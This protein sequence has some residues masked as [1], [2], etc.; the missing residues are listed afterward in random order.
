MVTEANLEFYKSEKGYQSITRWYDNLLEKFDFEYESQYV[1]TRF[2]P[3]HMLVSGPEDAEPL[4]LVQA[5][6]GSAPLWYHQMPFLAKDFRVYA[7]DTP[8]QPGRSAPN[9][10]AILEGGYSDWLID[11][12][13]GL[14]IERADFIGVSFAGWVVMRLAIRNP[15]RV[16]RIMMISPTG[17]VNARFP[18]GIFLR[19]VVSKKK[20]DQALEDDLT[21]RS[22]MPTGD[23]DGREFD[24][25]L[26]RAM[27]LATRHYKL[28]N[29]LGIL[30]EEKGRPDMAMA[31]R[32][33][34]S[35]P[36]R[37]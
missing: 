2:G 18:I 20:D 35:P 4:I 8:G 1:D 26:A 33:A 12:L 29:S 24:R 3:T 34:I 9:P 6:A 31:A 30:D 15:E 32:V 37:P 22:F 5:I 11:V 7:L 14:G 27:A 28:D 23:T 13:D 10:P 19:N 16:K 36:S 21:T 17:L 25:Q